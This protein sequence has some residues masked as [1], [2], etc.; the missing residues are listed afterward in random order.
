MSGGTCVL[1]FKAYP[2]SIGKRAIELAKIAEEVANETGQTIIVCPNNLDLQAVAKEVSIPVYAQH[3]DI[4]KLGAFT[5]SIPAKGV[6]NAG[7]KGSLINHSEKKLSLERIELSI[8]RCREAEIKSVVCT[9]DVYEAKQIALFEPDFIAIEPP[10]LIG[11]GVSVSTADPKI[12]SDTIYEINRITK[13]NDLKRIPVLCGAGISSGEDIR[14]AMEL[15]A[16]GVLL[17]SAFVNAKDPKK[18]LTEMVQ[19]L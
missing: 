14:K 10:E 16:E 8:M 9:A 13:V 4:N 18:L 17:A 5:G 15:G 6:K 3:V 7:G 19:N 1:N 12:V 11:T 2:N